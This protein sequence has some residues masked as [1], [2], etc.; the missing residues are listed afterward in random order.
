MAAGD[1]T[2]DGDITIGRGE[3]GN[4]RIVTGT[5]VLDGGNPTPVALA[6]YLS[7]IYGATACMSGSAATGADP[8]QVTALINGTTLDI[9]AWKITTGGAAGNATEIASTDNAR[10]INWMAMGPKA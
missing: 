10:V 7:A 3:R 6:G 8:N 9:Y 1:V 4:M 5:V 2:Y